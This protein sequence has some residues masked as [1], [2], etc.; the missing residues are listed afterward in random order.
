MKRFFS[1]TLLYATYYRSVKLSHPPRNVEFC[2]V[3]VLLEGWLW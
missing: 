1:E 2:H 3:M